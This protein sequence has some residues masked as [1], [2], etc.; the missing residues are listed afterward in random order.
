M[1][2]RR[3]IE[4]TVSLF[5]SWNLSMLNLEKVENQEMISTLD[6]FIF[7]RVFDGN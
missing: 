4:R 3:F 7:R 5:P 1:A 6:D 2:D